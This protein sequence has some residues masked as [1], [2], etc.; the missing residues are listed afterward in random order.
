MGTTVKWKLTQIIL[1][2]NYNNNNLNTATF[3]NLR[4]K[5]P[6]YPS[7]EFLYSFLTNIVISI[8]IYELNLIMKMFRLYLT[9]ILLQFI[10]I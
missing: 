7:I 8:V 1:Y 5:N 4:Q 2:N 3:H 10:R 6:V 9:K